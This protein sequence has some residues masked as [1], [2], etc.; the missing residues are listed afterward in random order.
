MEKKEK[1]IS[2]E[3]SLQD[4]LSLGYLYLLILGIL[5]DAI[6]YGQLGVNILSYSSVQD[7]LLSPIIHLTSSLKLFLAAFVGIPLIAIGIGYLGKKY[8]TMN[9]EKDWYKAK[10]DFKKYEAMYGEENSYGFMITLVLLC[11][12]G[13][14]IGFGLGS[15]QKIAAKLAN[16]ELENNRQIIF[17]DNNTLHVHEIGHNSEYFFYTTEN[18][19]KV[20]IVPIQDN[21]KK[22]REIGGE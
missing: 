14:F 2:K 8:H 20:T 15:G 7:I 16:G 22:I 13:G 19:T 1:S 10:K 21:I 5:K 18:D 11:L 6:F 3:R 17:T 9:R 12:F 4:Y